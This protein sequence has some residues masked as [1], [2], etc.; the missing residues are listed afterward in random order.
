MG[1]IGGRRAAIS[2]KEK[3][4]SPEPS[5]QASESPP[6][7]RKSRMGVIGGRREKPI[8]ST[9]SPS[10][11]LTGQIPRQG[12]GTDLKAAPERSISP[13][14]VEEPLTEAEKANRKRTELKRQ[15]DQG[16]G[17]KKRRKF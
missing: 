6:S 3:T 15:L 8:D 4:R 12:E 13:L 17:G 11:P 2:S 7:E 9:G 10:P 14:K 1:I 5:T 16:K